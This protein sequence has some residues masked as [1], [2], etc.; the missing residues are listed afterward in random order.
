ML[1]IIKKSYFIFVI[2]F[3]AS[4]GG[5]GGGSSDTANSAPT[6]SNAQI[7][8]NNGGSAVVGD[9]LMGSYSFSDAD[10]DAEGSSTYRWLRNG[11]AISG[12]TAITYTL[13]SDDSGQLI[14]FEVTPLAASGTLTGSASTSGSVTVTS[15]AGGLV[16]SGTVSGL[17]GSLS[18]SNNNGAALVVSADGAFS[19]PDTV[20][21]GNLYNVEVTDKPVDQVCSI[22]NGSGQMGSTDITNISVLCSSATGTVT[23]SGS[24]TSAVLTQVDSD[25]NDPQ[26]SSNVDNGTFTTAQTLSNF[27][28]VNGFATETGTQRSGFGDRFESTADELD[29][30]SVTLQAKQSIRMQVVDYQ[31]GDG[32]F[33]GDLDLYLYDGAGNEVARSEATTEFEVVQVPSSGQYFIAVFAFSGTSKYVLNLDAVDPNASSFSVAPEFR[34]NEAIVKFSSRVAAQRFSG[35]NVQLRMT[36]AGEDRAVLLSQLNGY[37]RSANALSS[38]QV[39]SDFLLELLAMNPASYERFN[40]LGAIKKLNQRDDVVYAEPNYVRRIQQVPN[41]T[42]YGLQWHYPAIKLPQAWDV[43]TGT[44]TTGSVIVAIVD[45]GVFLTH[46]DFDGQLVPGFDFIS[47]AA[48]AADGDGIDNNP[49]DPGDS[50]LAGSSSWH[51]THVAGTVAAKTNNGT[52][53]A[54]VSWGAKIMPLRVLGREGGS[55]FDIVQAVLFAAGLPN[56]SNTVPTQKADVINL[57][58][59]G[60]G[61]SQS[62][63]DAFNQVRNAGVIVVAASGNDNTSNLSYPASYDGVISVASTGF[64]GTRAPYSTFGTRV[65]VA[66]PGGDMSSDANNDGNPD[67]VLSAMVDDSS[68]TRQ[69]TFKFYEGTSM[70]TPHMAGV[71]ALMRAVHPGLTPSNVDT[72]LAA[73]DITNDAGTAG[74]DDEYGHGNIDAL[75]AVIAAQTLANGGT[76]P[77]AP[78]LFVAVPSSV[79]L[80]STSSATVVVSNQGGAATV[81]GVTDDADWLAIAATTVDGSGLGTYTVTATRTNLSD[82][83]YSG[84]IT[85]SLSTGSTLEVR[86]SMVVGTTAVSGSV[87][88]QFMLLIN[89]VSGESVYQATIVEGANGVSTY[90]FTG[91]SQGTYQVIGGSD[92]DNDGVVCQ[93]GESCG[94]YPVLN[95]MTDIV[96]TNQDVI[97]L[98]FVVDLLSNLGLSGSSSLGLGDEGSSGTRPTG[99]AKISSLKKLQVEN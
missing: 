72:L 74:R 77:E 70:A 94:G 26:A 13:T 24:F 75:K 3:V 44:P 29:V 78:P 9:E 5:G 59:G 82:S 63:Q 66:A 21:T 18:L 20:N 17:S 22:N 30:Y 91:V 86:V 84:K 2:L 31:Q 7:T 42:H 95:A 89:P 38:G 1:T 8:D 10:G 33:Q 45:T 65:D 27:V 97:G 71:L 90:Q 73:G 28:T 99:V 4:C 40:T 96:V 60:P 52:G 16:I 48:N 35:S 6:A 69:P 81:T 58:L 67:G 50:N 36:D 32:V 34:D 92:V 55:D 25:I 68:G 19:F 11:S 39:M 47:D 76:V 14:A 88:K 23:L 54:G 87:G 46:P 85:F 64:D 61:F 41:D 57:S 53:I 93:L 15:S 49:D 51:G 79:N 12:A 37:A 62:T 83:S 98:S 80:G 56:A 43:T